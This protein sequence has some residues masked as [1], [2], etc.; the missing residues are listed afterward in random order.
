MTPDENARQIRDIVS[1]HLKAMMRDVGGLSPVVGTG[2]VAML[3]VT[4]MKQYPEQ[5][6]EVQKQVNMLLEHFC[7]AWRLVHVE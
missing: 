6:P 3:L 7:P 2:A 5:V 4:Y 1:G